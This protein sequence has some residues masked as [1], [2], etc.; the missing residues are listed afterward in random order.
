[1]SSVVESG[2]PRSASLAPNSTMTIDGFNRAISAGMR[3]RPPLVVSPLMLAFA[4][5]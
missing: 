1:L 2:T 5:L 4:T 3:A